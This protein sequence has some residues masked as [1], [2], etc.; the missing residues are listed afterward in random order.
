MTGFAMDRLGFSFASGYQFAMVALIRADFSALQERW[1]MCATENVKGAPPKSITTTV[2][3]QSN[4]QWIIRGEKSF[5]TL[6]NFAQNLAVVV[7][8][9]SD[10]SDVEN[11][12]PNKIRI[13][14]AVVKANAAGV[15]IVAKPPLPF[16][17]EVP[18][19]RVVLSNVVISDTDFLGEAA[20]DGYLEFVKPFRTIEDIYVNAAMLGFLIRCARQF[21]VNERHTVVQT[22]LCAIAALRTVAQLPSSSKS[23]HILLSGA[24][25]AVMGAFKAFEDNWTPVNS[26]EVHLKDSFLRDCALKNVASDARAKRGSNAWSKL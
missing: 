3:R 10:V 8:D 20:A 7:R 26:Q 24:L 25:E 13:R 4:G 16:I 17:P 5:V 14:V 23:T 19:A 15:N 22:I 11:L 6:G 9:V 1:C 12:P 2:R 21:S 18:H